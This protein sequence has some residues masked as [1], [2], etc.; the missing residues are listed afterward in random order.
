MAFRVLNP[1]PGGR[2]FTTNK[3]AIRAVEAGIA[4]FCGKNGI[5]FVGKEGDNER[6]NQMLQQMRTGAAYDRAVATRTLRQREAK[7]LPFA[8]DISRLGIP[9]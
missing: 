6:V 2:E 7:H 4:V 1:L 5:R 8:G 9:A 3:R